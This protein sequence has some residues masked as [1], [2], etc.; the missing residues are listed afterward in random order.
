MQ[1][2]LTTYVEKDLDG[3][4]LDLLVDGHK[5]TE[6]SAILGIDASVTAVTIRSALDGV[7][8]L[9]LNDSRKLSLLRLTKLCTE[10]SKT[11][12]EG[13]LDALE[14]QTYLNALKTTIDTV[15]KTF[16][17]DADILTRATDSQVREFSKM[18]ENSVIKV[19]EETLSPSIRKQF[20]NRFM[21]T[22]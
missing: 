3:Q 17:N 13:R 15:N 4:V 16:A 18:I 11:M 19:A 14:I 6:I 2:Q 21:E 1:Q 12:A 10:L 8:M 20:L 7:D 5:P 22:L 9:S